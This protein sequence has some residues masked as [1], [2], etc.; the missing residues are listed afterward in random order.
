MNRIL[1]IPWFVYIESDFDFLKEYWVLFL[2]SEKLSKELIIDADLIIAHSLWCLEL[3]LF[4]LENWM[5]EELKDKVIHYNPIVENNLL[6][7]AFFRFFS[8]KM[9]FTTKWLRL[10]IRFWKLVF[11]KFSYVYKSLKFLAWKDKF[12]IISI[13]SKFKNIYLSRN[14]CF[15]KK[16]SNQ[17]N[18]VKDIHWEHDEIYFNKNTIKTLI[19]NAK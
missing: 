18:A 9:F 10:V 5:I 17:I 14:D 15:S 4:I 2:E 6:K 13:Y 16:Y 3:S 12:E 19:D 1:F 11:T 7:I 8:K